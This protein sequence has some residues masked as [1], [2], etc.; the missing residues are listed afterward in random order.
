MAQSPT[1]LFIGCGN[2]GA[3]IAGGALRNLPLARLVGLDPDLHR[4]RSLLPPD[5]AVELHADPADLAGLRPDLVILGVKPQLFGALDRGVMALLAEAPVVSVMAGIPLTRLA[6]VLGHGRVIRVMPNL[7]ALVGAGMSLGCR[8][9][10][11]ADPALLGLV[12]TL[13]AALGRFDWA[14]DEDQFERANPVFSCGPGFVFAIAEQMVA[15]AIA[16]GVPPDLADRLVRQTL[17]GS[18]RMLAE[19]PRDARALKQAVTSPNGTTQ[20]GLGVLEA[21]E[22]LP[23]LIPQTFQAAYRRA[24]ELAALA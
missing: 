13:F 18:A 1:I 22:A 15:G 10:G 16:G 11:A 5:A 4:A 17:L 14:A 19:D 12:E 6:S 21:P 3:S 24:L 2:M 23:A 20:A 7:P 8:A 9:E